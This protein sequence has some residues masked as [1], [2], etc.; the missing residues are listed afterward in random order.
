MHYRRNLWFYLWTCQGGEVRRLVLS[1]VAELGLTGIAAGHRQTRP[2]QNMILIPKYY[3]FHCKKNWNYCIIWECDNVWNGLNCSFNNFGMLR[4]SG[5]VVAGTGTAS[6]FSIGYGSIA[7]KCR[8]LANAIG[9]SVMRR[10]WENH[11]SV[12]SIHM[13]QSCNCCCCCLLAAETCT[14]LD[15]NANVC[16]A[17]STLLSLLNT[18]CFNITL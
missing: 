1:R 6:T 2:F 9:P 17:V 3:E 12:W 10:D 16:F 8:S 11:H 15:N 14:T 4:V 13:L 7:V 18:V 5:G